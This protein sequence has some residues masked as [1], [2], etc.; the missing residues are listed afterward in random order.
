MSAPKHDFRALGKRSP[1]LERIPW[2]AL[3]LLPS[4]AFADCSRQGVDPALTTR[5]DVAAL[6]EDFGETFVARDSFLTR[7]TLWQPAHSDTVPVP[8]TFLLID[9]DSSG[10]PERRQVLVV[11]PTVTVPKGNSE[12]PVAVTF[13]LSPAIKLPH[14]GSFQ[15]AFKAPCGLRLFLLYSSDNPFPDGFEQFNRSSLC[16]PW[17]GTF[18]YWTADIAFEVQLCDVDP[19]PIVPAAQ[20]SWGKVRA[21]YRR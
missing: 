12:G 8:I 14:L 13:D 7:V 19:N 1:M 21:I 20:W 16:P 5:V 17:G 2:F 10:L 18:P 4:F 11:G 3:L 15:A 9:A 6:G